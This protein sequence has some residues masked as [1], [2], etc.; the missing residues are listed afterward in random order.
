[1]GESSREGLSI[2]RRSGWQQVLLV[3][4]YNGIG[5][6]KEQFES[7]FRA[8]NITVLYRTDLP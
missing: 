4:S 1:L 8:S 5:A 7:I 3:G 2:L 6:T